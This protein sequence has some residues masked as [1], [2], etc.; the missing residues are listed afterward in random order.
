MLSELRASRLADLDIVQ[1]RIRTTRALCQQMLETHPPLT[2]AET[3]KAPKDRSMDWSKWI[4]LSN[5]ISADELVE[6]K[7]L[8]QLKWL[9]DLSL[10]K[11]LPGSFQNL[12]KPADFAGPF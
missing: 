2:S 12:T 11:W 5:S 9:P 7:L 1:Q 3:S 6:A 8:R 10:R 4:A